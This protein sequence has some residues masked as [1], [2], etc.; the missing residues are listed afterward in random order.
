M[1]KKLLVLAVASVMSAPVFA[2]SQVQ[3]GGIIDQ[4]IQMGDW[5]S[6][7]GRVNRLTSGGH[8]T[9]RLFFKGSE[10][11]GN[12]MK[13]NFHLETQPNP[14]Q[15]TAA[16]AAFWQRTATVG[17]SSKN[18]GKVNLG[19]QYTPW[20]STRAANDIFYTAGVGSNYSLEAGLTR[21][22]NSIRFDS[23]SYNGFSFAASY[24][25]GNQAAGAVSDSGD[26]GTTSVTDDL[27][28]EIGLKIAYANG[29]LKL[30]YGYDKQQRT[31]ADATGLVSA[32]GDRKLNHINGSYDFKVVKLVAGWNSMKQDPA[33]PAG[34]A[35]SDQRSWYVGGVM[36]V[37][38]KD[39]IKL[40]YTRLNRKLA[41]SSDAKLIAIGYE[42][43][44]SKRTVVYAT[45][46]KMDN[47]AAS[48]ST[49]LGG[50]AV[51]AGFDPNA[52]QFGLRHA[53]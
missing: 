50:V 52:F 48:A 13:A 34:A 4:N 7:N 8:T 11:L 27:G 41:A 49:L 44:M 51:A 35:V 33:V 14:D 2:Q 26:E 25:F 20:F 3:I 43:P 23:I 38:G 6:A 21:I 45:Y 28:R 39:K 9:N 47:D 17:L 46:A 15:G 30:A 19:R 31:Q 32:N 12:G 42:H 24:S 18:W 36:P 16:N 29:P 37:F 5:S 10:D 1:Q 22:S 40:E 53:F